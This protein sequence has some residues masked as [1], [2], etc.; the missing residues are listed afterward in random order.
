MS[1]I[2]DKPM[3]LNLHRRHSEHCTGG[4][5]AFKRSY[6]ADELRRKLKKCFCPIYASG[7]LGGTFRCKN[8]ERTDWDEA[9]T[10]VAAWEQAGAW[11]TARSPASGGTARAGCDGRSGE[12]H[13]R[14]RDKSVPGQPRG[15]GNTATNVSEVS[16]H[17]ESVASLR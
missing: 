16:N 17:G 15:T 4:H 7:T 12:V 11:E 2:I 6:E 3:R 10:V 9:K 13:Y 14:A 8:T 5:P 1:V